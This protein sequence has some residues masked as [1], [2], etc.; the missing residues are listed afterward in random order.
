MTSSNIGRRG[1]LGAAALLMARP[2]LARAADAKPSAKPR[3]AITTPHGVIVVE[4]EDKKAPITTANFLGY[5]DARKYENGSIY[6]ASRTPGSPGAGSIQGKC[7]DYVRRL[8]PIA[9][10][11]TTKTGLRHRAGTISMGRTKP[12]TATADFFICASALPYLDAH[13]GEPGDNLG[14]AAFGQVVSG[15]PVVKKI[16]ALPTDGKAEVPAM[17]GQILTKP[18][19][20]S[21]KRV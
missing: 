15:M 10:E 2:R 16:L 8:P 6:R 5:V 1:L 20:I 3:V 18:L 13:P 19:A 21:M 4:L 14:Y 7:S 17:K 12:G 11:S 9:H